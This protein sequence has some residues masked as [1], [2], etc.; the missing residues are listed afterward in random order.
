MVVHRVKGFGNVD[1]I[2]MVAGRLSTRRLAG[3]ASVGAV[4][5][6]RALVPLWGVWLCQKYL[7]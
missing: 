6:D 3:P 7:T 5:G 2:Q 4:P 1:L